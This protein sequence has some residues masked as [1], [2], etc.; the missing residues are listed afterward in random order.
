MIITEVLEAHTSRC[1]DD[2]VDRAVVAMAVRDAIIAEVERREAE[3]KELSPDGM[4]GT[5]GILK[6]YI[7]T[8][9]GL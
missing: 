7:D 9:E 3:A 5:G 4:I 8:V 6:C 2:N 1:L